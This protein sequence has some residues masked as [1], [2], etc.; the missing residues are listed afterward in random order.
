MSSNMSAVE[1]A[2][3]M[4]IATRMFWCAA[5]LVCANPATASEPIGWWR[6]NLHTHTLWSDGDDYPEMVVQ[7][8]KDAGYN[9]LVL[10]DHNITQEG[11]KWV[12]LGTNKTSAIALQKYLDRFPNV[13][14]ELRSQGGK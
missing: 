12:P 7:A 8:Y 11:E 6:G 9:F 3:R 1:R 13:A 14:N 10:S 2:K 4:N 5:L